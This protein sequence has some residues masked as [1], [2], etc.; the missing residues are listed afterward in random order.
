MDSRVLSAVQTTLGV[1][2]ALMG[3]LGIVI[4]LLSLTACSGFMG[5]ISND[6]GDGVLP[7]LL[8][9]GFFGLA[10]VIVLGMPSLAALGVAAMRALTVWYLRCVPPTKGF[11]TLF[12]I[13]H[14]VGPML[15]FSWVLAASPLI[16]LLMIPVAIVWIVV[17]VWSGLEL[18]KGAR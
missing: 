7:G 10:F 14:F 17:S 1:I 5:F 12:A 9:G 2:E 6:A 4:S 15:V 18:L 8:V 3:L 16:G 13:L 11:H